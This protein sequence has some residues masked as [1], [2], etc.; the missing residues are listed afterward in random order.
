MTKK[1]ASALLQEY[2]DKSEVYKQFSEKN[3]AILEKDNTLVTEIGEL[4]DKLKIAAREHGELKGE[5][6][7]VT[8]TTKMKRF[9]DFAKL[10]AILKPKEKVAVM[11]A[12]SVTVDSKKLDELVKSG[13]VR[14]EVLYAD[15]VYR[16]E[17]MTSAVSFKFES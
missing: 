4:S 3:H 15:G 11:D 14:S 6:W 5:H 2:E 13:K 1:E 9:Y 7:T 10:N 17:E 12:V 16:E 8:V